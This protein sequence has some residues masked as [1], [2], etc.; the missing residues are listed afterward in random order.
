MDVIRR[1]VRTCSMTLVGA[2]LVAGVAATA[3]GM[4][5]RCKP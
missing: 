3:Y 2:A 5:R 1:A 4:R